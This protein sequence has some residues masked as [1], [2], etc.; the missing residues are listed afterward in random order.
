VTSEAARRRSAAVLAVAAL[1]AALAVVALLATSPS[2]AAQVICQDPDTGAL[3]PCTTTST[4]ETTTTVEETT[5]TEE[6]PEDT[7]APER[8]DEQVVTEPTFTVS[9]LQNVL[10]P[11]DGTEG[12]ENTTT[13]AKRLASGSDGLSDEQLI[14]LIVGGLGIAAGVVGLLTWRYW[15]ATRPTVAPPRTTR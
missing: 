14:L 2:G 7:V 4:E 3:E 13:T 9:T 8:D 11:G 10:I 12:A 6:E 1:L 5:T 15:T